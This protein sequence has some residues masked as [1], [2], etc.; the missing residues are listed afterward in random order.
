[1]SS[2]DTRLHIGLGGAKSLQQLEIL[3]P[4]GRKQ[5]L[6]D[7]GANQILTVKEPPK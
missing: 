3:W 2:S 1:L 6:N 4:S 5:V 7:V